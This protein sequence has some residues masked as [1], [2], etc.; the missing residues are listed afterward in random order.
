[1]KK[2]DKWI[3]FAIIAASLLFLLSYFQ[4]EG[5]IEID[6]GDT[7]ATL[8]VRRILFSDKVLIKSQEWPV[9]MPARI[10]KPQRLSVSKVQDGDTWLLYSS[11]PWG[12][13]SKIKV[14][15]KDITV[16]RL[17][18]PLEIK[19]NVRYTGSRVLVDFN[20]IGRSGEHYSSVIM[21]NNKRVAAPKVR[22]IDETGN[23]LASGKLEYG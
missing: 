15:N 1:M 13:L 18:P 17:G 16:L 2:R 8:R 20:I 4:R 19:P 14:K 23:I 21:R 3:S 6:A 12:K 5:Q 11:G 22:I 9:T 10:Y 7:D